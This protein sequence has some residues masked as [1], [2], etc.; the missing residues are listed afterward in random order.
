MEGSI[1]TPPG[2]ICAISCVARAGYFEVERARSCRN[3][4]Q[5]VRQAGELSG[6]SSS[7]RRWRAFHN[8]RPII[9]GDGRSR[10]LTGCRP[11]QFSQAVRAVETMIL[12]ADI[13]LALAHTDRVIVLE[14]GRIVLDAPAVPG[15]GRPRL[16]LVGEAGMT[17]RA[18]AFE[19]GLPVGE[20]PVPAGRHRRAP[21]P[22]SVERAQSGRDAAT[23]RRPGAS[24]PS[25]D[26]GGRVVWTVAFAVLGARSALRS[27]FCWRWYSHG[28]AVRLLRVPALGAELFALL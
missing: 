20:R 12:A 28:C 26:R 22:T 14:Q 4:R 5:A 8:D 16:L 13:P 1:A 15:G 27:A 3:E 23:P 6:G 25:V 19:I 9:I 7:A 21:S 10:R 18:P 17:A 2:T 24:R 11:A